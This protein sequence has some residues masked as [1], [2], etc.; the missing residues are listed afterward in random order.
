MINEYFKNLSNEAIEERI[1]K[2][3]GTPARIFYEIEY[4]TDRR[5]ALFIA[6]SYPIEEEQHK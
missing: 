1:K 4:K 2:L 5:Q 3:S 6:L